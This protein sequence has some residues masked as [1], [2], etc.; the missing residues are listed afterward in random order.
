MKTLI[1]L[2]YWIFR[3]IEILKIKIWKS[4]INANYKNNIGDN[5]VI[6]YPADILFN[7]V[8]IGNNVFINAGARFWAVESKILIQ[9]NVVMGPNVTIMAGNHNYKEIGQ[10]IINVKQKNPTD[11]EDVIIEED[12]WIGCNVII[13]KGV[14][15]HRGA[16]VGAGSVVIKDVSPYSIVGGNPAK[17][18]K[19][20]FSDSDIIEHEKRLNTLGFKQDDNK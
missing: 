14:T 4:F 18:I 2:F 19:Y 12:V 13:L 8:F 1:N 9:N 7:N 5:V 10:Y 20:R 15:I 11:D 16:I 3:K 17:H 6:Q